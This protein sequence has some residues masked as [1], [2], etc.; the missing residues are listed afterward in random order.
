[1]TPAPPR[2]PIVLA[3]NLIGIGLVSYDLLGYALVGEPPLI[4]VLAWVGVASW[5]LSLLVSAER[6]P[7]LLD[8]LH[9]TM[10]VCGSFVAPGTLFAAYAVGMV[11]VLIFVGSP[12]HSLRAGAGAVGLSAALVA[13]G[14]LVVPVPVAALVTGYSVLLIVALAALSRRQYRGGEAQARALLEERIAVEQ[15]RALV[16]GLSERSRIARD[17]HDVLAHSLGGL[18][19]QLEAVDALLESGRVD[20]ARQRVAAARALAVSGLADAKQAV[21]TL[22]TPEEDVDAV[23]EEM[24]G[25]HR[26]LGG[27]VVVR[28]SGAPAGLDPEAR[29]ALR[30]GIQE[31]LTNARRHAPGAATELKLDWSEHSLTVI[32]STPAVARAGASSPGGGH[33]LKGMRERVEA[34]GGTM[35]VRSGDTFEV[36]LTLPRATVTA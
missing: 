18:V 36:V 20:A 30:R 1:V 22:R 8:A 16:A 35:D 29:T 9:L 26:S 15:E 6:R 4:Q 19:I 7:R 3:L 31:L 21:A 14:A 5:A 17:L 27:Q 11:G 12:G 2:R 34:A 24:V 25:A 33:G 23:V 28:G 32:A 10:I 13:V